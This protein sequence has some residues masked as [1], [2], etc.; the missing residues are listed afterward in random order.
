MPYDSSIAHCVLSSVGIVYV[1]PLTLKN[2]MTSTATASPLML[3]A[4]VVSSTGAE[5]G[6]N[7]KMYNSELHRMHGKRLV[8]SQ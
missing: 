2:A 7:A 6:G 8:H 1:R 3:L 4:T 5:T